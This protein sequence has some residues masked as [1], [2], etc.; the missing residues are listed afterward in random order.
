MLFPRN[1]VQRLP[2][3]RLAGGLIRGPVGQTQ[4]LVQDV[5]RNAVRVGDVSNGHPSAYRL[6]PVVGPVDGP[7]DRVKCAP[8]GQPGNQQERPQDSPLTPSKSPQFLQEPFHGR[9]IIP[10][11]RV[12]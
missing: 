7:A 2:L 3:A 12:A 8:A 9:D 5:R 11:R 6:I 10:K 1:P 4:G